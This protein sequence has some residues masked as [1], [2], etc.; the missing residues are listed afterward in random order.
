MQII[1][2]NIFRYS[3]NKIEYYNIFKFLNNKVF[4]FKNILNKIYK[5][6]Q[7]NSIDCFF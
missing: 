4:K 1:E 3:H 5:S 2:I 6:E 7:L